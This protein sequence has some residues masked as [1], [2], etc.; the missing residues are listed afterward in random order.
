MLQGLCCF[1]R[2]RVGWSPSAP[3]QIDAEGDPRRS[4]GVPRR[5][6]RYREPGGGRPA[7]RRR[8]LASG[9]SAAEDAL[10][11]IRN[12]SPSAGVQ[13]DDRCPGLGARAG[14]RELEGSDGLCTGGRRGTVRRI[15]GRGRCVAGRRRSGVGGSPRDEVRLLRRCAG[16]T[17]DSG[18]ASK[19]RLP[20]IGDGQGRD[21]RRPVLLREPENCP[22]GRYGPVAQAS[23]GASTLRKTGTSRRNRTAWLSQSHGC[24]VEI[25]SA[26][27]C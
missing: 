1:A 15:A 27:P 24:C 13:A 3:E 26:P 22:D 8:V 2:A 11:S 17:L 12:L 14:A 4:G 6:L 7:C 23:I 5:G 9:Q 18:R 20:S 25:P 21:R 10:E 16:T 19:G